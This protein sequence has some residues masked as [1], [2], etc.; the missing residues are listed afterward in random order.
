MTDEELKTQIVAVLRDIAPE[1]EIDGLK[2]DVAFR[3]QFEMDSV[4]FLNFMLGLEQRLGVKIPE[5]DY[6]KY[7]TLDGC[8]AQLAARIPRPSA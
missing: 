6:P 5:V 3:D 1:A 7:A 4:D 8:L 2:P